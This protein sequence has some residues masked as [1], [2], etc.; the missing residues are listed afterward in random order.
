MLKT[1]MTLKMHK[2]MKGGLWPAAQIY[3]TCYTP[4]RLIDHMDFLHRLPHPL[5]HSGCAQPMGGASRRWEGSRRVQSGYLLCTSSSLL[6]LGGCIPFWRA[7]AHCALSKVLN[8]PRP[9]P[10]QVRG[11]MAFHCCPNKGF[12]THC[13]FPCLCPCTSRVPSLNSPWLPHL[14]VPL[15]P[16]QILGLHPKYDHWLERSPAGCVT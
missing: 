1:S 3:S 8:L 12:T 14:N 4:R 13:W 16:G 15:F 7:W 10:F 6:P 9:L 2:A 11:R 5:P